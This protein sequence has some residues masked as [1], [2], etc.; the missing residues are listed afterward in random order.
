MCEIKSR[1]EH[2]LKSSYST[3]V[4]SMGILLGLCAIFLPA[5]ASVDLSTKKYDRTHF[6]FVDSPN[7]RQL[8]PDTYF[9][10]E[11]K[12]LNARN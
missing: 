4:Q 9:N 7:Q 1:S 8:H 11:Y 12:Y 10:H 3:H 6:Y 5:C 2:G